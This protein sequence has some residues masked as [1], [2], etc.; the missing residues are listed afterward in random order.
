MTL[1]GWDPRYARV[2][3]VRVEG[4]F[5]GAL[6]D[7]NGDGADVNV[8]VYLRDPDGQWAAIASGNGSVEVPG[9]RAIWTDDDRLV[10]TPTDEDAK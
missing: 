9:L 6:V 4:N 7:T 1:G 5:A 8:D 10:L 3:D 2:L